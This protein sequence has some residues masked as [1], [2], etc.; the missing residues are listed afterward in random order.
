[1]NVSKQMVQKISPRTGAAL[2]KK[3]TILPKVVAKLEPAE[4][5]CVF[6][7]S[8]D[9]NSFFPLLGLFSV[10]FALGYCNNMHSKR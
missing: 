9:P 4:V 8:T 1:M 2:Y 10:E 3:Y 7:H 5:G 6:K